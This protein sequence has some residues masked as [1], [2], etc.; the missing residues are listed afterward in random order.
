MAFTL[1]TDAELEAAL[2]QLVEAQGVSRQEVVRRAVMLE[3]GRLDRGRAIDA[4]LDVELP[5]YAEAMERL[6]Q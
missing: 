5:R 4:I 2:D 1:R 3:A 6:G